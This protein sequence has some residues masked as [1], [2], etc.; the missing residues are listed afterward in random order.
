MQV[1]YLI[2]HAET[3]YNRE[4]RVQGYTESPLSDLGREQAGRLRG[5]L[6]GV[7]I[8]MAAASP[9]GRAVDTARIALDGSVPIATY[10]GLREMNLGVW[11][12]R[13][14]AELKKAYPEEVKMWFERPTQLRLEGGETIRR[15]RRRVTTT[16]NRIR[17]SGGDTTIAVVTHGG[18]IRIYLTSLL[19]MKLDDIWR[20]KIQNCS[21]TRVL[22]PADTPRI[23]LL[24]DIHHLD[25]ALREIPADEPRLFP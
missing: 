18:V 7:R 22:F 9:S 2:R 6:S 25:G 8:G 16:M 5:R 12:G 10:E 14:A 11:E 19:G 20:F 3:E 24:G 23:D 4:G 13:V 21:L 17:E 15:F 1:V